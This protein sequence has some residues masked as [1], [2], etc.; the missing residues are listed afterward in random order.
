[1]C[2]WVGACATSSVKKE[3]G[4]K[5]VVL[6][7]GPLGPH[8]SSWKLAPPQQK[9]QPKSTSPFASVLGCS[10]SPVTCPGSSG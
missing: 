9:L 3:Q 7:F 4:A 2:V 6:T 8:E 1:M 5:S 10:L